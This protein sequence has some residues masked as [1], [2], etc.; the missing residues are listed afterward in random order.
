MDKIPE[1]MARKAD[2]RAL[3]I[4]EQEARF[5]CTFAECLGQIYMVAVKAAL[6]QVK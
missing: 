2:A 3:E 6:E 5:G 4:F 1:A